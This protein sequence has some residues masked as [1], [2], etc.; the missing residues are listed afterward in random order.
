M[1]LTRSTQPSNEP[2]TCGVQTTPPVS[3]KSRRRR[4]QRC[5]GFCLVARVGSCAYARNLDRAVL[6]A[7]G[8][9]LGWRLEWRLRRCLPEKA[10]FERDADRADLSA[11]MEEAGRYKA[12]YRRL[13]RRWHERGSSMRRTRLGSPLISAPMPPRYNKTAGSLWGALPRRVTSLRGGQQS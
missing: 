4:W 7:A 6:E 3:P 2:G 9:L 10:R 13:T 12:N 1:K 5:A 11:A 8:R